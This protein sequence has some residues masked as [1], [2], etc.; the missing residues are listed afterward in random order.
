VMMPPGVP[1]ATVTTGK[2]GAVNAAVL[3]AQI[4]GISDPEIREK[5]HQYKKEMREKVLKA[6]EEAKDY[7]YEI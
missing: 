7:S 2:A 1:V 3:A 4:L 5:L 6:N